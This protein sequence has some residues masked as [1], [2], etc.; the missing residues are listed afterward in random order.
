VYTFGNTRKLL[1]VGYGAD[2]QEMDITTEE[3]KSPDW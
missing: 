1:G 3:N 2:L